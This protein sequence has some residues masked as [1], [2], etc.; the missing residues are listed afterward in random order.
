LKHL[1]FYIFKQKHNTDRCFSRA[2]IYL[3]VSLAIG[4]PS[5][6]QAEPLKPLTIGYT[7]SMVSKTF[8]N[9][10]LG[11]I[12]TKLRKT[13]LGYSVS[14]VTKVQGMA[15][16]LMG[17]NEEQKCEFKIEQQRAIPNTY[18]GGRI[19]KKDYEVNFDWQNRRLSFNS[20]E[21]LDMP[22][23]Y[24]VDNCSMLFAAALLKDQGLGDEAFYVVDGKSKRVRGYTLQSST[25]EVL[26]TKL[27][28]K[29]TIKMVLQRETVPERTTTLWLST[30]DQYIPLKVEEKR[31]SRT[32]TLVVN[33]FE[34]T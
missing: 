30:Q 13:E 5:M 12:E 20:D 11:R 9:A 16:I 7:L 33:S 1:L 10:T 4:G 23:G 17:S 25:E 2:S 27:G 18:E 14:S 31:K 3:L 22:Q 28:D 15:A 34:Q 32:T 19:G 26:E 8:G 24:I 21:S 29:P 6:T